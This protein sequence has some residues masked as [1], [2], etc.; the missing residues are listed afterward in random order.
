MYKIFR[1]A[2]TISFITLVLFACSS[3]PNSTLNHPPKKT[4]KSAAQMQYETGTKNKDGASN[5]S[6]VID[7]DYGNGNKDIVVFSTND[8]LSSFNDNLGVAGIKYYV[9]HFDRNENFVTLVDTGN[10]SAGTEEASKSKEQCRVRY[11]SSW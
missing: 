10:F 11:R 3:N 8:T 9:D 5:K 1:K 2:A 4:D 7:K 6:I